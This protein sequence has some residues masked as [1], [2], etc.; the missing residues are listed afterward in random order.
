MTLTGQIYIDDKIC[1]NPDTKIAAFD[2][3]NVCRGVAS[4]TYVASRD[5]YFVDMVIYGGS[6]SE[7][8]SSERDLTFKMYDASTGGIDPIVLI[9]I[10]GKDQE[11]VL[12][13]VPDANYG[14]YNAPVTFRTSGLL[15]EPVAL[16]KGWNWMS[17]YVNPISTE[18][19]Y[20][21]PT[22][23]ALRK[24]FKNIKGKTEFATINSSG[25]PVGE[26]TNIYPG[27]MYKMQLSAN[28]DFSVHG[29]QID[30]ARTPQT[31][32][33]GYNWIGPLS[34][35]ILSVDDAFADLGPVPGDRVKSREGFAEYSSKGYG[36]GTLKSIVPGGG[37]IYHST[38]SG[39][40]TFYYP[41]R[42]SGS[43]QRA[44]SA[45]PVHFTPVDS[46]LYP[47]NMSIIAVVK[48]DGL[49]REDAEVGAF[50]NGECRGAV[51]YNDGYYFLTVMG[52]SED[53]AETHLELRVFVDGEEYSVDNSLMFFSDAFHGSLDEPYVLDVDVTAIRTVIADEDADDND[54][55]TLQGVKLD[56]RPTQQGIYIHHGKKVT[57]KK[58]KTVK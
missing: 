44:A 55:Y 41:A 25:Q 54:W 39:P 9:T 57:I 5:A 32:R 40:K 52:S 36:E 30:V 53:D 8:S 45:L 11:M 10:P 4:P 56:R 49:I 15:E 13:Y 21:L 24:R 33:P 7:L 14:S 58:V 2:E 3:D 48:K 34:S 19:G 17:I 37:Y 42:S 51:C 35:S 43:T 18:L 23:T 38:A 1:E 22:E 47:D 12:R 46:Y 29:V 26:L 50:I 28:T 6:A 27:S 31:I 16:N 20:I